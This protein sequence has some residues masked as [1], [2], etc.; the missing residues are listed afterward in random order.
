M[1]QFSLVSVLSR[2]NSLFRVSSFAD[3]RFLDVANAVFMLHCSRTVFKL[4]VWAWEELVADRELLL[5]G[6]SSLW[7]Q[8]SLVSVLSGL[9][10][11]WS[12]FSLVSVLSG[13]CSLWSLFSL[14]S[15]LS[16]LCS[17]WSQFS[18]VPVLSSPSSLWPQFSLVPVLSSEFHLQ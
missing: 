10:S 6:L 1:S 3:L 17:L 14:V 5:S 4:L 16:G 7:S 11:L 13:L 12:L 9:C 8:F 18:L 15:V 2:L